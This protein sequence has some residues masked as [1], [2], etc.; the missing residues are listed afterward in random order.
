[1]KFSVVEELAMTDLE[2]GDGN[3][4]KAC[5]PLMLLLPTTAGRVSMV[6]MRARLVIKRKMWNA[7]D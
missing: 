6:T 3:Y 1:M 7:S 5:V 4:G 2:E